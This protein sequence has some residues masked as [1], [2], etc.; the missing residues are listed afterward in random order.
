GEGAYYLLSDTVWKKIPVVPNGSF[1][2]WENGKLLMYGEVAFTGNTQNI[3]SAGFYEIQFR[4]E[5]VTPKV[6]DIMKTVVRLKD[7][8]GDFLVLE[9]FFPSCAQILDRYKEKIMYKEES[10]K[11]SY[12]W[13]YAWKY[14]YTAM[15]VHDDM[16]AFF[17][18]HYTDGKVEYYWRVTANGTFKVLPSRI[19]P[20]YTKG[21]YGST[22]SDTLVIGK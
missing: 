3:L 8:I 20:M 5:K 18:Y 7:G 19:Y 22:S 9:D 21:F 11:F 15:E 14:W 12:Y 2:G 1:L 4:E 13:Y 10:Y 16:V 17:M 6:G